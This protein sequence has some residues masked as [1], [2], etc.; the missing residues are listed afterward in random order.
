MPKAFQLTE[1]FNLDEFRCPCCGKV[2]IAYVI[3]YLLERI[4]LWVGQ[5]VIVTSGYRCPEHNASV[6]GM[7]NSLHLEGRA[8][9]II[10]PHWSSRDLAHLAYEAGF[11]TCIYYPKQGHVHCQ[12]RGLAKKG[13]YEQVE[14]KKYEYRG[15]P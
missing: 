13:L 5:P 3:P 8:V 15:I 9:D 14:P 6:G 2:E 4:R 7:K 12:L 10:T 11:Y 1:H